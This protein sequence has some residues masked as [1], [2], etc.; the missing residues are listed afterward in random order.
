MMQYSP[1][2][3][4][5]FLKTDDAIIARDDISSIDTSRIEE[6]FVQVTTRQGL[7]FTATNLNALELVLQTR[8]SALE[9]K[10]LK[11]AKFSWA[12]HNLVAHPIMQILAFL[13]CYKLAFWVHD[14]TVP[15]NLQSKSWLSTRN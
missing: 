11:A 8:P 14:V 7:T 2:L 4:D 13:K 5:K 12:I 6:L 3:V 1:S 10:R 15:K 9:G